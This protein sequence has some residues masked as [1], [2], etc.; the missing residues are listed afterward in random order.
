MLT[1]ASSW[2]LVGLACT[3]GLVNYPGFSLVDARSWPDFHRHH[4]RRISWAVGPAWAAQAIGLVAWLLA[5]HGVTHV[6]WWLCAAGAGAAVALTVL[7]AVPH[8]H[9]LGARFDSARA[10]AL[11]RAHAWRTLCWAITAVA[12]TLRWVSH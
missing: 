2:Y 12:A 11:R 7:V 5:D 4:A 10:A 1:V 6:D 9:H 3:V 8:H